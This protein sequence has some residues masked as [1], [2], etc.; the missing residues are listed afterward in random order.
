MVNGV[1]TMGSLGILARAKSLLGLPGPFLLDAGF[2]S[3]RVA[4]VDSYI[5]RGYFEN[6]RPR[7]VFVLAEL[8][9]A[10]FSVLRLGCERFLLDYYRIFAAIR[11][12]RYP[13]GSSTVY[14]GTLGMV[15]AYTLPYYVAEDMVSGNSGSGQIREQI[16]SISA[17][18]DGLL[19]RVTEIREEFKEAEADAAKNR[20]RIWMEMRSV[21][22][23]AR[24]EMQILSLRLEKQ[25]RATAEL[26]KTLKLMEVPL[27]TVVAFQRRV[28]AV[29][30]MLLSLGTFIWAARDTM[31]N[32]LTYV[33]KSIVKP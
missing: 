16:G 26:T 30:L 24:S 15:G 18:L 5:A 27:E 29:G 1:F 23:D 2:G 28:G 31:W 4:L 3:D 22:H 25:E 14:H 10:Y 19:D 33:F 9:R 13:N 11:E 20:E 21:K 8:L 12:S 32:A 7:P 6:N 17:K